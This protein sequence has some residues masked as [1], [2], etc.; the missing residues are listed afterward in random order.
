MGSTDGH[1]LMSNVEAQ[2]PK[3]PKLAAGVIG[4]NRANAPVS[5]RAS[6]W[7]DGDARVAIA[8]RC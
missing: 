2:I 5:L 4:A 3:Q 6:S 1:P 8:S 7:I